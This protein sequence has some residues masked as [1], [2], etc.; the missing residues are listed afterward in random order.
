MAHQ[1]E[2]VSRLKIQLHRAARLS[3]IAPRA[4]GSSDVWLVAAPWDLRLDNEPNGPWLADVHQFAAELGHSAVLAL[5]TTPH[6]AAQTWPALARVLHF[7]LW[8]AVKL[9]QPLQNA[10]QLPSHHAAL[11]VMSKYRGALR[12]TKTRIG[13]TY[14]PA[15]DKTT[16]DYG[17]KKHTYHEYGTLMSDVWRD[18]AWQPGSAPSAIADR[19]AD[20]LGLAPHRKLHIVRLAMQ[21]GAPANGVGSLFRPQALGE[22]EIVGRKGLLTPSTQVA[23]P[24]PS[25]SPHAEPGGCERS[26]LLHGDCLAALAKIPDDSVDFCFADPPYNLAKRYDRW[27]DALDITRYFQWCDR[28]LDELARVLRP[29]R[30]C[31]V[32][33]IPQWATRHVSHLQTRLTFQNWIVWEGLSLPVRMIMPAH[34]AIVCF[35]KGPPRPLPGLAGTPPSAVEAEALTTLKESYCLRAA[36]LAARRAAGACDREPVSD[37]WW[38][39]HRLKHNVRRV[40][41]PCQLPP[42]LMR[43]LIALFTAPGEVV[44]DPFNGAGTTSLCAEQMGRSFIGIELSDR[45]HELAERRHALLRRGGDPFAKNEGVPRAK[46]SRVPRIGSRPYAVPK[47]ELQLEVRRIARRLGRLPSR[48]EVGQFSRYPLAYFD[49]Y[50]LSWGEVCAAARTTGMQETRPAPSRRRVPLQRVMFDK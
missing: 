46:N 8:I 48:E 34:Y 17:G 1:S 38:D 14:C 15:C 37:L 26:L 49:E 25:P 10:G 27:D 29:G 3:T 12:H 16:K 33:N 9:K 45:Y 39:I 44:L 40:D 18:I 28:W 43:R 31:A 32:L 20:L 35:S 24:A 30:S 5:L 13:Y 21:Y 11:L 50:F 6:D 36:C 41:H 22:G 23:A 19:L 2:N 7:Q 4:A 42:Q 47:K